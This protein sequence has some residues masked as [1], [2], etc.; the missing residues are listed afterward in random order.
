MRQHWDGHFQV[1]N[2]GRKKPDLVI[3]CHLTAEGKPTNRMST[4][5]VALEIKPGR[6]HNGISDGFGQI[7]G[8]YADY[9][10]GAD[11]FVIPKGPY[12][13]RVG[14]SISVFALATEFSSKGFLFKEEDRYGRM[15]IKETG[16]KRRLYP[17][18][19]SISRLLGS[20]KTSILHNI[21]NLAE[22]PNAT[23]RIR[24]GLRARHK[25]PEVGVLT[26]QPVR[27]QGILL[28]TSKSPLNWRLTGLG[29]SAKCSEPRHRTSRP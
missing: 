22:I 9:C 16:K 27:G 12:R 4:Q 14:I 6:K 1:E 20:Q 17:V 24:K 2:A 19:F 15:T 13:K 21:I 23:K 25:H 7:L 5:Y 11:Y 28:M 26:R 3:A 8:Y 10:W 18:T 29:A